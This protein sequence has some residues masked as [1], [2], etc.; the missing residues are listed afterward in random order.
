LEGE[1]MDILTFLADALHYAPHVISIASA[2]C[3]I[4]PTPKGTS[5]VL[6]IVSSIIQIL[7]LN[8]G[9]A[10]KTPSTKD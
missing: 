10:K 1:D 8:V 4:A 7:A 6:H 5:K 3:A 9:E 2:I